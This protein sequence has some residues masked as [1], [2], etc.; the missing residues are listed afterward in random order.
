VPRGVIVPISIAI[1]AYAYREGAKTRRKQEEQKETIR[2]LR[3]FS[4]IQFLICENLRDLRINSS[5][6]FFASS[7]LRGNPSPSSSPVLIT[8]EF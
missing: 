4:Q 3:R 7:R 1:R 5:C 2:R 8:S 6:F